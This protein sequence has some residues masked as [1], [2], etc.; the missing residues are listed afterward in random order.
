MDHIGIDVHKRESQICIVTAD[1]E[2]VEKRIRTERERFA[3]VLGGRAPTKIL[4][5]ASTESEWVA[6]CL[7]EL[8]HEVIVADPNYAL[9]YATRSRRIKT[10]RRDAK[11][12]ADACQHGHYR[13]AH[14]T[15]SEQRRVR[16]QLT[17]RETLV[18]TRTRMIVV[19]KALLSRHGIRVSGGESEQFGK[20]VRAA[21]LL[22]S[23][24]EE[25]E[26]LL[27]VLEQLQT[28]VDALDRALE[29]LAKEQAPV[30]ALCTVP[31]VGPV[32][33]A[34]FV[35]AVD[36]PKRFRH[37]H[38]V[39]AYLGLV[40]SERSSGDK[41]QRGPITKSGPPRVRSLLVQAALGLLHHRRSSSAH[42]RDWALRIKQRR[43]HGIAIV[44]LARRLAGILWAI[45]RDG[46]SYRPQVSQLAASS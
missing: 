27:L 36:D 43:G 42:L 6:R 11:A 12:L 25:L 28:Q 33:A 37:A 3:A 17:V 39:E 34:A 45:L 1:G 21:G 35:A 31:G 15:S 41:Q 23:V 19:C 22:A 46:T 38:Q 26:P 13:A 29:R 44:A 16:S 5:E 32:T 2:V 8:G 7:E 20:R 10:D 40:P 14:R 9:M 4:I 24:Q 30:R 18:R